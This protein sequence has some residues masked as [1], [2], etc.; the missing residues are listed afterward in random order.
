M[1]LKFFENS[2]IIKLIA[3]LYSLSKKKKKS[4][5]ILILHTPIV[6]ILQLLKKMIY[7]GAEIRK[8]LHHPSVGN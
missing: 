1:H 6:T 5:I 3:I 2:A 7:H 8:Y 4:N